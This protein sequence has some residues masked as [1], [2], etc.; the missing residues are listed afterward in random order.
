MNN[1]TAEQQQKVTFSEETLP[2]L[3]TDTSE[4]YAVFSYLD[5]QSEYIE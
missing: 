5:F 1:Q 3:L 4:H 2:P